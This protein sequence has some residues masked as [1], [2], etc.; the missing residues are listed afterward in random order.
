MRYI[1]AALATLLALLA[2]V[3]LAVSLT[4]ATVI[5]AMVLLGAAGMLACF[6]LFTE[7]DETPAAADADEVLVAD[8]DELAD[9]DGTAH[10]LDMM[11]TTAAT[12]NPDDVDLFIYRPALN[13][14]TR[15]TATLND[16][17]NR[18]ITTI[19]GDTET[20]GVVDVTHYYREL[21][22][23]DHFKNVNALR[24]AQELE[25]DIPNIAAFA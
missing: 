13:G 14:G 1:L 21:G 22:K 18:V 23:S 12:I 6:A 11:E 15:W 17:H 24:V 19:T 4:P 3:I 5:L 20:P 9:F 10:L 8:A 16:T 7:T 25:A 2:V